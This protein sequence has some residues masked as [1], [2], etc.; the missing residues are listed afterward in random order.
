MSLYESNYIRLGW[1]IAGSRHGRGRARS[2]MVDRRLSAASASIDERSRYTTTLTLT[3]MFEDE[4]APVV[5]SG[6]ADPRLSRC[7]TGRSAVVRTLASAL[8]A[9]IAFARELARDLGDRWLRN[10]MLNKWLD[11]CVERGHRFAIRAR[12]IPPCLATLAGR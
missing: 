6:P 3:Y 5:G 4:P 7:A 8:D 9:G 1:L 2:R 12:E 10:V 11:Y